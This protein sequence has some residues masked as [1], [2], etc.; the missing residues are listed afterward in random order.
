MCF[1]VPSCKQ[2]QHYQAIHNPGPIPCSTCSHAGD[3][4]SGSLLSQLLGDVAF[5]DPRGGEALS[6]LVD[7]PLVG[8]G[9][10]NDALEA[11]SWVVAGV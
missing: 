3:P 5:E 7:L 9:P 6:R 8:G 1:D 11:A 4:S 2:A 10:G